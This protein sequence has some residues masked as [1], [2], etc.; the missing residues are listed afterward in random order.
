MGGLR[1]YIPRNGA[2]LHCYFSP[3][4][5]LHFHSAPSKC[6]FK[7]VL[8]DNACEPPVVRFSPEMK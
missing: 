5:L 6:S 4:E 1:G 2:Y 8:R 3:A 7:F